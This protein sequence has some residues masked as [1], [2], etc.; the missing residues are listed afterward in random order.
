MAA[1]SAVGRASWGLFPRLQQT[2]LCSRLG[3]GAGLEA[4]GALETPAQPSRCGRVLSRTP[5]VWG[6]WDEGVGGV[7]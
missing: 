1:H 4:S 5:G 7:L 6:W 3:G 2:G